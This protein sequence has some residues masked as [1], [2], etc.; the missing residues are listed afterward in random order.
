[1]NL[2][3]NVNL[4]QLAP[5]FLSNFITEMSETNK[6]IAV[7]ATAVFALFAVC[8]LVYR[9]KYSA[10]KLDGVDKGE[11]KE[12]VKEVKKDDVKEEKKV[13]Q[14]PPKLRKTFIE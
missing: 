11:K 1:M 3:T 2:I 4:S 12:D 7:L 13:E 10:K 9:C 5:S 8:A 6:K 14:N